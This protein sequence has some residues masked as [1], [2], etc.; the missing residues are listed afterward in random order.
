MESFPAPSDAP[1]SAD[2]VTTALAKLSIE[3]ASDAIP[4]TAYAAARMAMLDALG[5][6]FAG[7]DAPGVPAVVELTKHWGGRAEATVWFDGAKVPGPAATFANSVQLH[8]MDFDDYHPPSDAH[9]TSVL[10]PA[11]LAVA[12]V[13]D[14]SGRDF[15]AALTLGAEVVG[16]LGRACMARRDHKGFLPTSVIGGFGGTAAACRLYGCSVEQTADAMGIWYAHASGNRQPLFDRTLTKRMQ[17]AIAARAAVFASCLGARGI[18]GPRRIIDDQPASL[19]RIYG[20]AGDGEASPPSI[21][22]VMAPRDEWAVEELIYKRFACCGVSSPAMEAGMWL[23]DKHDLGPEQIQEVRIF[24]ESAHSPFG[25]VAWTDSPSPQALAQF[26]IPY[27]V[28]S[29]IHNRRYGPAEIAPSRIAEDRDVDDL[30]R[31]VYLCDWS[32][33]P[34]PRPDRGVG[35]QFSLKDGRELWGSHS[36]ARWYRSPEDDDEIVEKFKDNIRF[37]ALLD[38]PQTDQLVSAVRQID[39]FA[40][41]SDFVGQWLETAVHVK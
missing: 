18:T 29:A 32:D 10:V 8:A 16:R 37:S 4:A 36:G 15:L 26:C 21:G 33:W 12:E 1:A 25:S 11:A 14:A 19:T 3:T 39:S 22:E 5:C 20:Y 27:A 13:R 2:G 23:A 9:I 38:E 40:R 6:A 17:P 35:V 30:A 24:G 41:I 28:A 34:G 31:R 7:H